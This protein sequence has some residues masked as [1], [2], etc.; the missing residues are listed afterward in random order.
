M[1]AMRLAWFSPLPPVRAGLSVDSRELLCRLGPDYAI[2]AFVDDAVTADA[3]RLNRFP[4]RVTIHPA[5]DF[6]W[7][8]SRKPYD[9]TVYQ[10]GNSA[11]HAYQ[12]PYL[13]R[14]PGLLVLHDGQ[15]HHSRAASLM[16]QRRSGDYRAEFAACQPDTS[17]EAAELAIAGFDSHLCAISC[18]LA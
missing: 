15:L 2:D 6:V 17:V 1:R 5:H 10:L 9:L 12:W 11:H 3:R 18:R 7:R 13:F 16:R 4:E 8:E 14:Y